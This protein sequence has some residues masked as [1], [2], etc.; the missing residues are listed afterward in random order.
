MP[1]AAP[2]LLLVMLAACGVR[3]CGGA[4]NA[5]PPDLV[6]GGARPVQVH[7]PAR[8]GASPLPL[9]IVLHPY[10]GDPETAGEWL[11]LRAEAARRGLVYAA[12]TG[13]RDR[14]GN[15]FW[16]ASRA[17][18]DRFGAQ[19]D[20]VAYLRGLVDEI[21]RRVPID[22]RRVYLAG[23]SNGAFMAHR[24]AC[25]APR[26]VAAFVSIA[27]ALPLD[28]AECPGTRPVSMVQIHG[29]RDDVVPYRGGR[30]F[31]GFDVPGAPDGAG[32][33]AALAGC[34]GARSAPGLDLERTLPGAETSRRI[35]EGCAAGLGVE[36][37]TVAGATHTPRWTPELPRA[38]VDFLLAH[39]AP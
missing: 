21:E 34:S 30:I 17:C 5:G 27:G 1:R 2:A 8:D 15:L 6:V 33:F 22:P 28:P 26:Q 7:V 11:G 29:D 12:P 20:D 16:N 35:Y 14:E 24:M 31:T 38:I 10:A 32:H 25:E 23:F 3:A 39:P 37:W 18:C 19:V 36:L 9:L 4:T 13:T